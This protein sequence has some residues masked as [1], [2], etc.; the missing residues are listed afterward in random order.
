MKIKLL[1]LFL[2]ISFSICA[3]AQTK[4]AKKLVVINSY[5]QYL[6]SIKINPNNELVEIKKAI[7]SIKLD[8]RY[9]TTNNF[10][11]QVMYQQ[12]RAFARKPVVE[13]LKKIQAELKKKG[14]GLKIFDGYRPYA[15]TVAFY[16]KASDKNFVANPAKG[17]K[18]NRGCAVDLTIIDLKTGKDLVMATP[19]DSF[20]AAAAANYMPVSSAVKK[21]RDFLI[22]SMQKYNFTVLDNEWWHFDFNGWQYYALMDI[23][24]EKL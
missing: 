13:S 5:N 18:H 3:F 21:N 2:I 16:Q 20:S 10:M 19:Y 22:A 7:P 17:S 14:Y 11:K 1:F 9:A 23:P 24:F 8:I 12:A 6:A 15:V 4:P